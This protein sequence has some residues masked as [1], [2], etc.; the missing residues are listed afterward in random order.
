[1]TF[2]LIIEKM[3]P[4][5]GDGYLCYEDRG[6]DGTGNVGFGATKRKARQSWMRGEDIGQASR[7][8]WLQEMAHETLCVA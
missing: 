3:Q 7:M 5:D 4:Y 8:K 2:K 1:M 6:G